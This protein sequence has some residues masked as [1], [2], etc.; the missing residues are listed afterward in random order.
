M[1]RA[2]VAVI[3][4]EISWQNQLTR[5]IEQG[6]HTVEL[7][8]G[9]VSEVQNFVDNPDASLDVAVVD[10]NL[11]EDSYGGED[12]AEVTQM[13]KERFVGITIVGFT[14]SYDGVEGADIQWLKGRISPQEA[15]QQ[16]TEL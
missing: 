8:A 13:L 10:G 7:C 5:A 3:D 15:Q 9:S 16:I 11:S 1:E 6:G 14:S 4:D 2:K 12:G